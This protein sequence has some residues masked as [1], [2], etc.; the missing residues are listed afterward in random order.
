MAAKALSFKNAHSSGAGDL[1][2]NT[3]G[4]YVL[5]TSNKLMITNLFLVYS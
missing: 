1:V 5:R 4:E 3:K 2:F